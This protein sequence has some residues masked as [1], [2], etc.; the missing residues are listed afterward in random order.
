MRTTRCHDNDKE[1][2]KNVLRNRAC[3]NCERHRSFNS[4]WQHCALKRYTPEFNVCSQWKMSWSA[5]ATKLNNHREK[6][7]KKRKAK[8][9]AK[10]ETPSLI[11]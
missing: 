5:K 10:R 1:T 7:A 3:G 2:I 9:E 8:R 6:I 4:N 11:S